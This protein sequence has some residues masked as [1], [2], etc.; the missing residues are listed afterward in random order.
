MDNLGNPQIV[1]FLASGTNHS[2]SGAEFLIDW[3]Y[4]A[5]RSGEFNHLK[6][7]FRWRDVGEQ[8]SKDIQAPWCDNSYVLIN[9]SYVR[10]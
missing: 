6:I 9:F 8:V 7:P 1:P 3:A 4:L 10:Y 2:T 5:R